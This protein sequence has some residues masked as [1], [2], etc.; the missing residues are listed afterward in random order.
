M[1]RKSIESHL[2]NNEDAPRVDYSEKEMKQRSR[3]REE[4]DNAANQRAQSYMEFDDMDYE[5]WYEK[6][7][8]NAQAYIKPKE[9]DEDVKVVTGTTR[10]KTNTVV[11]TL[12]SYNLECDIMAYDDKDN[13]HRELGNVMEKM[14]RKSRELEQPRYETKK[15]L[16]YNELV[17]QGN[18]FVME[19]W[20]EFSI[21]EKELEEMEFSEEVELDKIKWKE[22][23]DKIYSY[24]NSHL[25][26]GLE[27]FP[28]NIRQHFIELQPYV[29]VRKVVSYSEAAS[30]FGNWERFK[31]VPKKLQISTEL[32]HDLEYDDFQMIEPEADL[33]EIIY[34]YNKWRNE[35]QILLNGVLM[36]P[37]GFPLSALTGLCEY[38]LAKGD[39]EMISPNFFY[40][41]GIGAKTKMDQ[42]ILDEM[43]KMMIVKT[44]KSYKPPLANKGNYNIG[45]TVYMPGKIFKNIDP[46]KLQPIGEHNGVTPAEFNMTQFV[47]GIID[48]K[49]ITP[50]MEGQA[51]S[52]QATARQ[53]IEQKEQS[54][55]KLGGVML[56]VLNLEQRMAWMRIYNILNHWTKATD[57]RYSKLKKGAEKIY[58]TIS[59][60]DTMENGRKGERIIELTE[61]IP[62]DEQ[63]DAEEDILTE[64]K[65]KPIRKVYVNPKLLKNLKYTWQV[66]VTPTEKNTDDL[67]A[68]MFEEFLQKIFTIF[69]PAGKIP[70][71][72]YLAERFAQ[73]ND[74]DP[75]QIWQQE[76]Q[77]TPAQQ[78]PMPGAQGQTGAQMAPQGQQKPSLNAMVQ[79]GGA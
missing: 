43:F 71:M 69:M 32:E 3:I 40:S 23:M 30:M 73:V 4:A 1:P 28:G 37:V 15:P 35:Y 9:N 78:P 67:K 33:V 25:L 7:K 2:T 54:M 26:T 55:M 11:A 44:R 45:P 10:E 38:P 8:K 29:I 14:V 57:Q 46:E 65:G 42:A 56:G 20:D 18:V 61:N 27:V 22:R 72:D 34:Y 48:G 66:V 12:L 70:N 53:I 17:N 21:K 24:C 51:P 6:A 52:K 79:Q 59:I 47:K 60:E 76:Q 16:I 58:K 62:T 49:S 19:S 74:E 39:G 75:D 36:L 63:V 5:S 41:R 68:A 31:Y 50:I 77:P 13:E 64:Y